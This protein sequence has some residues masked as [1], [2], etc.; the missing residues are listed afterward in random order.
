MTELT[1]HTF[2]LVLRAIEQ[3][4]LPKGI[5]IDDD[6]LRWDGKVNWTPDL[7]NLNSLINDIPRFI[8][9]SKSE[10]KYYNVS[11][12]QTKNCLEKMR[13]DIGLPSRYNTNG[14]M[15]F[16]LLY[17]GYELKPLKIKHETH[18]VVERKSETARLV[19]ELKP[20]NPNASFNGTLRNLTHA[21]C[22][23]GIEYVAQSRHAHIKGRLH[24]AIMGE[25]ERISQQTING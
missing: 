3:R 22:E 15:I 5:R 21:T 10:R 11:S 7:T 1:S 16:A 6:G 17:L 19:K 14:E 9:K 2:P 4:D 18:C 13:V 24:K 25:R 8:Q 23:C 12:Y 20:L